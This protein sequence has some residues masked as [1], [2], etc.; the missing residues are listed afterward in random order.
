MSLRSWR[1][2]LGAVSSL[3]PGA[4]IRSEVWGLTID[5]DALGDGWTHRVQWDILELGLE[6]GRGPCGKSGGWGGLAMLKHA[7]SGLVGRLL[8]EAG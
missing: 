5:A 7:L 8:L 4:V 2:V 1:R 3:P 6:W